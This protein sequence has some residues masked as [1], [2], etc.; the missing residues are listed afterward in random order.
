MNSSKNHFSDIKI[1]KELDLSKNFSRRIALFPAPKKRYYAV[2]APLVAAVLYF[3]KC[4][5]PHT[6]IRNINISSCSFEILDKIFFALIIE[7]KDFCPLLCLK[8][9][10]DQLRSTSNDEQET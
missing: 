1:L 4:S 6:R 2:T 3:K 7:I 8:R 9:I 5:C 10:P